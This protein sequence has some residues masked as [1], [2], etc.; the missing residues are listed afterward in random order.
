[1]NNFIQKLSTPRNKT[2]FLLPEKEICSSL[3]IFDMYKR[4]IKENN[5]LGDNF[6]KQKEKEI[7][8]EKQD[9]LLTA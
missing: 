1:M 4:K 3:G 8:K 5:N 6:F 7:E 9:V 2:L